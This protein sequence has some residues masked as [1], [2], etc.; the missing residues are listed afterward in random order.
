MANKPDYTF[1]LN[2]IPKGCEGEGEFWWYE[3]TEELQAASGMPNS[4]GLDARGWSTTALEEVP[5]AILPKLTGKSWHPTHQAA[6]LCVYE[7]AEGDI[8]YWE[9][10]GDGYCQWKNE[11][12][13]IYSKP[14]TFTVFGCGEPEYTTNNIACA[15]Q[16]VV[17]T[18][19]HNVKYPHLAKRV[20]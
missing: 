10:V 18:M 13:E 3:T 5:C 9:L 2:Y 19:L 4:Y 16:H 8:A 15:M 14:M 1:R 7:S 6:P 12:D 11:W 20:R 17:N